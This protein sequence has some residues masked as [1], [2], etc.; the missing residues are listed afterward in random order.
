MD[1]ERRSTY[2]DRPRRKYKGQQNN[3]R[4]FKRNDYQKKKRKKEWDPRSKKCPHCANE[5]RLRGASDANGGR[6]WKCKNK[7][8][9][10]TAWEHVMP[11]PPVPVVP[12]SL[13]P[14]LS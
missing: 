6:S 14:H 9:G 12:V 4:N 2:E 7:K 10:R 8:C 3:R 11:K 13:L 1:K 5:M